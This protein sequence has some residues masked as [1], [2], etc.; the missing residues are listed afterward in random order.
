MREVKRTRWIYL[1]P[2]AGLYRLG[3]AGGGEVSEGGSDLVSPP[4]L[5]PASATSWSCSITQ[6]GAA[7][8]TRSQR[9]DIFQGLVKVPAV[10]SDQLPASLKST[11]W[12]R[13]SLQLQPPKNVYC[14]F[15]W[16]A[17]EKNCNYGIIRTVGTITTKWV[18]H[19]ICQLTTVWN[20]SVHF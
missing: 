15:Y 7:G 13:A 14:S 4:G 18:C 3:A 2:L 6:S 20:S 11:Q 16:V 10:T 19:H 5:S 17:D 1:L 9:S 8:D 12:N